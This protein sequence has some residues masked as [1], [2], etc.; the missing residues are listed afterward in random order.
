LIGRLDLFADL[1]DQQLG[2]GAK[3]AQTAIAVP[4]ERIVREGDEGDA[5]YFIA[6][7]AAEVVFP[8]RRIPRQRRPLWRDGAPHRHDAT[9]R[10]RR[11]DLLPAACAAKVD[12]DRFMQDN[13]DIRL[14]IHK[15]AASRSSMNRSDETKAG[16]A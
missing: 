8:G 15:I 9:G 2:A 16:L 4:R 13:R 10:R 1:T 12:F 6:S 11:Y 7:G 14:V 3:I 5:C